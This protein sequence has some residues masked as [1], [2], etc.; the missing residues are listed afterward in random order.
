MRKFAYAYVNAQSKPCPDIRSSTSY[1]LFRNTSLKFIM[2]AQRKTFNINHAVE[3]KPL[4][5]LRIGFSHLR[6]H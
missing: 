5:R 2:P 4:T 6:E 3:T 1:N